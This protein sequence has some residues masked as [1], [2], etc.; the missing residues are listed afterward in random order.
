MSTN[1][2]NDIAIAAIAIAACFGASNL[3][4]GMAN[5]RLHRAKAADDRAR[6]IA[7]NAEANT[8]AHA[9]NLQLSDQVRSALTSIN[10]ANTH[11]VS[12]AN[13]YD[14]Y[15]TLT[16]QL[17]LTTN[18]LAPTTA[19]NN[20]NPGRRSIRAASTNPTDEP[21]AYHAEV[22]GT[23]QDITQFLDT[24]ENNFG[25]TRIISARITPVGVRTRPQT[26][27]E[28]EDN[29]MP[30]RLSI[31]TLHYRIQPPEVPA[32]LIASVPT[33]TTP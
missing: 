18:R 33:E 27:G 31:T 16:N 11:A 32:S 2:R 8:R 5:E 15:I 4:L 19:P 17:N 30:V 7:A 24:I 1:N 10:E 26:P 20:I 13:L 9:R 14:Q 28:P 12:A 29:S 6:L 25:H 22:D 3:F 23:L 21:I